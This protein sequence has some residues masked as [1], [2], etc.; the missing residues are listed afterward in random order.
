[1]AVHTDPDSFIMLLRIILCEND[2]RKLTIDN[3][4]ETIDDFCS[5]LKMKLGLEGDLVI[6]Y[7]D[8]DFDNELVI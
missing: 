5:I 6:Q 3:L 4:P 8:P 1:M 7:K 2:I